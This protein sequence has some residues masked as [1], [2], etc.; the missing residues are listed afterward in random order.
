MTGRDCSGLTPDRDPAQQPRGARRYQS[1]L[2][3]RPADAQHQP[4]AS[5]GRAAGRNLLIP[6]QHLQGDPKAN[7]GRHAAAGV[8][9]QQPRTHAQGRSDVCTKLRTT[10][11]RSFRNFC[12]KRI[13]SKKLAKSVV[14]L[15]DSYND[16]VLFINH[17]PGLLSRLRPSSRIRNAVAS[18]DRERSP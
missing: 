18:R 10:F 1:Q 5:A 12:V 15:Q 7:A 16:A 8:Q 13:E 9:L 4:E 14:L 17:L 3:S 6:Q 11:S 2:K